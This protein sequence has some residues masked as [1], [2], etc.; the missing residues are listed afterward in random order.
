MV[1]AEEK[2]SLKM[3]QIVTSYLPY[4]SI[5]PLPS[6]LPLTTKELIR[7]KAIFTYVGI[8]KADP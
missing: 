2:W 1:Q 7:E 6:A 5:P 3:E 4:R 8:K